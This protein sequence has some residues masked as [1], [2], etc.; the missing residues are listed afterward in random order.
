[1]SKVNSTEIV[2]HS[3]EKAEKDISIY[4]DVRQFRLDIPTQPNISKSATKATREVDFVN[5]SLWD[6]FWRDK[7]QSQKDALVGAVGLFSLA[8]TFLVLYAWGF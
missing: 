5:M 2:S 1:M 8:I 3:R 6:L 4:R 7:R